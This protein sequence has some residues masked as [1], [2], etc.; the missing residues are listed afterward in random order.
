[1]YQKT[2]PPSMPPRIQDRT[3]G[4]TSSVNGVIVDFLTPIIPKINGGTTRESLIELH[5]LISG[6]TVS[7][8][9]KL[10]GGRHGHL[11]LTMTTEDYMA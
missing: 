10:G 7:M 6:N 5:Q 8:A 2:N 3:T 9:S 11:T 4:T 1:M